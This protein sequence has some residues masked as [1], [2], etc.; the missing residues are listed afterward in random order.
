MNNR[1]KSSGMLILIVLVIALVAAYLAVTQM[2]SLGFGETAVQQTG[3]Q[4]TVVQQAQ[5]LVDQIN[6]AQQQAAQEP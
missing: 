3:P 4:Q 1:G 5:G 2:G 6:Q